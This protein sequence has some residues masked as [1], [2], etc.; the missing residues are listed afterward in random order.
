MIKYS[1]IDI[2]NEGQAACDSV[3]HALETAT[4]IPEAKCNHQELVQ[5]EGSNHSCFCNVVFAHGDLLVALPQVDLGEGVASVEPVREIQHVGEWVQVR[6]C[7]EV[8]RPEVTARPPG[9][10]LLGHH[11]KR[12]G[13][14]TGR[15]ANDT[16]SLHLV[17]LQPG[18]LELVSLQPPKSGSYR[19][20]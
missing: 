12:G 19:R 3:H 15:A 4:Y 9:T 5:A 6:L 2:E 10:A 8:E 16:F 17:K 14:G 13:P 18:C 7:D 1:F 11:V 20:A